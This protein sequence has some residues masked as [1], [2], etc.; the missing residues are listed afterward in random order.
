[1]GAAGKQ[2]LA[3]TLYSGL[4]QRRDDV[5]HVSCTNTPVHGALSRA[6][7][8]GGGGGGGQS[9]S[10]LSRVAVVHKFF[11]SKMLKMKELL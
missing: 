2:V 9:L 8:V 5:S 3:L 7:E 1:M 4:L 10:Q 11:Q 6:P